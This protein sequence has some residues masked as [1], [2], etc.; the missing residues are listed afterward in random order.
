MKNAI[1]TMNVIDLWGLIIGGGLFALLMLSLGIYILVCY[2]KY[3]HGKRQRR[4]QK[5]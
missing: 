5:K 1:W 3:R 4:K 2:I